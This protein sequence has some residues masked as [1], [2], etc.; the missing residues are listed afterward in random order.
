MKGGRYEMRDGKRVRVSGTEPRVKKTKKTES[1]AE[2]KP[3]AS[4]EKNNR[5]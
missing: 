2:V 5:V 4:K 3:D 1:T